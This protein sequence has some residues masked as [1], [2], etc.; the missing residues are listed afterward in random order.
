MVHAHP[1]LCRDPF[2]Q[3]RH[4]SCPG[5]TPAR[6]ALDFAAI[7]GKPPHFGRF[8][9]RLVCFWLLCHWLP[10]IGSGAGRSGSAQPPWLGPTSTT[11]SALS[12]CPLVTTPTTSPKLS[13]PGALHPPAPPL[14]LSCWA[15]H[16]LNLGRPHRRVHWWK[17]AKDFKEVASWNGE[18]TG[19]NDYARQV[20]LCWEKTAKHKR[21]LL[22][23][24]LASK[25]TGRA[26][27][28]T[29]NLDHQKLGKRN[30]A[31]YLLKY[32]QDRLCRTAI[33]DAGARLE[34]LLIRMRRPLGMAMSQWANEVLEGYRKV[35]RALI[36]ARQ[37]QR[38]KDKD[39]VKSMS[40]PHREPPTSPTRR[41]PSASPAH[42]STPSPSRWLWC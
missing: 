21:K 41:T 30:G 3:T 9:S 42:R 37:L 29:P 23:P 1:L 18:P 19:W 38:A 28:V 7:G 35:Q 15:R 27:A 10:H 8:G 33:P 12:T 20:R 39:E 40:E 34:D 26:W 11:P 36:R 13:P 25:L 31:K 22:G 32:L 6:T 16:P 14:L 24:E 4:M 17:M 2:G 5:R